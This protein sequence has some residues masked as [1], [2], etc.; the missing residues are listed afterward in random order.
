MI[1]SIQVYGI[2]IEY[3]GTLPPEVQKLLILHLYDDMCHLKPFSEKPIQ[4]VFKKTIADIMPY[5]TYKIAL[6]SGKHQ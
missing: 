4:V 3:I 1:I 2:L 5:F 6:N